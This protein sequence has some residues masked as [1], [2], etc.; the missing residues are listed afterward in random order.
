MTETE[1]LD[2]LI[3][4]F[5]DTLDHDST[6]SIWT[7]RETLKWVIG[8]LE[9]KRHAIPLVTPPREPI[10][11]TGTIIGPNESRHIKEKK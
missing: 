10:T 6:I 5:Q 8:F 1:L 2:E 4:T 11:V 3:D 9:E 7:P